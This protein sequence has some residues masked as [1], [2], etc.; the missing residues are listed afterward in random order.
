MEHI[1]TELEMFGGFEIG[2]QT[3]LTVKYAD[4]PVLLAEEE[5]V[6]QA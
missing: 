4:E 2:W 5:T 6:L 3:I 1:D